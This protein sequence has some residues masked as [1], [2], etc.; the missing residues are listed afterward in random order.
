M[1]NKNVAPK[2]IRLDASTACQLKC[3]SCETTKGLTHQHLGRGFLKFEN[4]QKIIQ[5]NP[6]IYQIE[7]SNWGEI[8]L[9]PEILDIIQHSYQKNVALTASNGAN[10]NTVKKQVLEGLVKYKFRHISCSIDGASQETYSIYRVGGNFDQVI[11]NIRTINYYKDKYKSPFPLMNWQF[12]VFGHNEHEINAAKKLAHELNMTF[13]P[14]LTWDDS[15][16]P[17]QNQEAVRKAL[18]SQVTSRNEYLEKYDQEYFLPC[19]QLW[20]IPQV[21]WDGRILGCCYN[22]WGD[23]GQIFKSSDGLN[24]EQLQYAKDMLSGKAVARDGIPCTACGYYQRMQKSGHYVTS[25]QF[26]SL[27][28]EK[29]LDQLGR[30][31][32]W[33]V[34][35]SEMAQNF[36]LKHYRYLY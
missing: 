27:N 10:L 8:F 24:T 34:N 32:V 23:F 3:P 5:Q 7:L 25:Q 12:V 30:L 20:K 4:F 36:Y 35:H 33:L 18:K 22:Y 15:F 17:I 11:E 21:N 31:G 13:R 29:W 14:K 2:A 28:R 1:P 19:T 6:S 26:Q 9:N 16:S